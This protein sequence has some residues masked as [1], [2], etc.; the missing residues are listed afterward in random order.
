MIVPSRGTDFR[1]EKRGKKGEIVYIAYIVS[2]LYA[3]ELHREWI[4]ERLLTRE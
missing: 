1:G 2:T 3:P 4:D